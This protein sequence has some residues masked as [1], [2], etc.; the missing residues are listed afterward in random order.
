[1]P[2][3]V[4][5]SVIA[6]NEQSSA[7]AATA[8]KAL[9]YADDESG[10]WIIFSN[11]QAVQVQ[12]SV[13]GLSDVILGEGDDWK[14][15]KGTEYDFVV[16]DADADNPFLRFGDSSYEEGLPMAFYSENFTVDAKGYISF[17]A[18][19]DINIG[20]ADAEGAVNIATGGTRVVTIGHNSAGMSLNLVAGSGNSIFDWSVAPEWRVNLNP[21]SN[22]ALRMR[23][24]DQTWLQFN[25]TTN[26]IYFG[27][28]SHN[29]VFN[30]LGSGGLIV[31]GAGRVDGVLQTKQGVSNGELLTVGGRAYSN[32]TV[33]AEVSNTVDETQFDRTKSLP[34]N[35]LTPGKTLR[36]RAVAKVLEYA[37]GDLTIRLKIGSNI[38]ST[39]TITPGGGTYYQFDIDVLVQDGGGASSRYLVADGY[40][41]TGSNA[42]TLLGSIEEVS[43]FNQ[44]LAYLISASAQWTQASAQNRVKLLKLTVS[45][46]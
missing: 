17:E 25:T 33:S 12:T 23:V 2:G 44:A 20:T 14:V 18:D 45:L 6:L 8:N 29:P 4:T 35:T 26:N 37:E 38:V 22:V 5:C 24:S 27:N 32:T 43:D 10:V 13:S 41:G 1:M 9:L 31:S 36:L 11:G 3:R 16:Y 34:A 42:I 40:V 46:V 28:T 39:K 15:R 19:G 30:I 21:A 7:P